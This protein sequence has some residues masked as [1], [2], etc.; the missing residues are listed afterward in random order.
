MAEMNYTQSNKSTLINSNQYIHVPYPILPDGNN[1]VTYIDLLG[2]GK[3]DNFGYFSGR[4]SITSWQDF[5]ALVDE[6]IRALHTR[7]Q[8]LEESSGGTT[9]DIPTPS[10]NGTYWYVGI[11]SPSNPTNANENT[12]NNKWTELTSKPSQI[13]VNTGMV[14]GMD[15]VVAIWYIAIPHSYGFQAY[16]SSGAVPD[17]AA[18]TKSQVTISGKEYDLFTGNNMVISIN[19]VFK[20]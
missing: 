16:D 19:A 7:I 10:G 5:V 2:F 11:V 13:S 14:T 17:I 8:T 18:F 20:V 15:S 12:G 9:P 3:L 1:E 6:Y 4:Q